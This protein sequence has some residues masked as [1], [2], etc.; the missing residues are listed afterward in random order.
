MSASGHRGRKVS[1]HFHVGQL[2]LQLLDAVA[3]DELTVVELELRE[4][5]TRVELLERG[6][7]DKRTVVELEHLQCLVHGGALWRAQL[8]YALVRDALASR[9]RQVLQVRAVHGEIHQRGV[10]DAS[11]LLE[12]DALQRVTALGQCGKARVAKVEAARGLEN[13]ELMRVRAQSHQHGVGQVRAPRNA[14][15]LQ[16]G[17]VRG[18]RQQSLIGQ[19]DARV[20]AQVDETLVAMARQALHYGVVDAGEALGREHFELGA[21]RGELTYCVRAEIGA[22]RNVDGLEVR[23]V[24]RYRL[25]ALVVDQAGLEIEAYELMSVQPNACKSTTIKQLEMSTFAR[26]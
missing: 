6:V 4:R 13:H 22:P 23:A 10:R 1:V 5:V 19:V 25:E 24:A 11:A 16:V 7:R 21:A 8:L 15:E 3:R 17:T 12:I 18:H 20:Q 14:Q 9:Q 2:A 26:E